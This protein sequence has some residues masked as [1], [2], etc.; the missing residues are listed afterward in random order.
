MVNPAQP[1]PRFITRL[2]GIDD[3]MVAD[4]PSIHQVLPGLH[5]FMEDAI[6]VGHNVGFDHKFIDHF[7]RIHLGKGVENQV[8][9]TCKLARRLLPDLPSKKLTALCEHFQIDNTQAHRAMNDVL[10]TTALME[11]LQVQAPHPL[12]ISHLLS[13]QKIARKQVPQ[14]LITLEQQQ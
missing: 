9:C 12:S 4:A 10:A 7:S 13:L 2:T 6:F 3:T 5:A 1:I 11:R 8:L 14:F